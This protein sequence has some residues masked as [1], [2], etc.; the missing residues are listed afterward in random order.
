MLIVIVAL[1]VIGLTLYKYPIVFAWI[2]VV[3]ANVLPLA[4]DAYEYRKEHGN[5]GG[6][7]VISG[8]VI[9]LASQIASLLWLVILNEPIGVATFGIGAFLALL[10]HGRM[11]GKGKEPATVETSFDIADEDSSEFPEPRGLR[12]GPPPQGL[13]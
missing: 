3:F 12:P 1:V 11:R 10:Y 5:G 2:L 9:A 6:D 13:P 4:R 7:G 8:L